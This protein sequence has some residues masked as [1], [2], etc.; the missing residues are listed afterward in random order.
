MTFRKRKFKKRHETF[1]PKDGLQKN[2]KND[3][4]KI[5]FKNDLQSSKIS[6]KMIFQKSHLQKLPSEKIYF[7]NAIKNVTS[8]N[9]FQKACFDPVCESWLSRSEHDDRA[10]KPHEVRYFKKCNSII[11]RY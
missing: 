4:Q 8:K 5:H 6:V 10:V 2:P 1:H 3:L 9:H 11:F 7:K